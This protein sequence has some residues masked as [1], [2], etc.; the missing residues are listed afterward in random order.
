MLCKEFFT[1]WEETKKKKIHKRIL[2]IRKL[3]VSKCKTSGSPLG[4]QPVKDPALSLLWFAAVA[5]IQSVAQELLNDAGM[6]KKNNNFFQRKPL[7]K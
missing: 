4:A 7:R 3:P 6:A 1:F 2:K 5:R